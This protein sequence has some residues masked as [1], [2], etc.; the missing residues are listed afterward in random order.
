MFSSPGYAV[1]L[2]LFMSMYIFF[3]DGNVFDVLLLTH[4]MFGTFLWPSVFIFLHKRKRN[5]LDKNDASI[6]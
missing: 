2:L 5:I 4:V 6:S 1:H 3:I